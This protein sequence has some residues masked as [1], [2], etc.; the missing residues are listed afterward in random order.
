M[1]ICD[2]G[3]RDNRRI[4][5]TINDT[6]LG[7]KGRCEICVFWP[8]GA[9]SIIDIGLRAPCCVCVYFSVTLSASV[10]MARSMSVFRGVCVCVCAHVN[11]YHKLHLSS[12][13]DF[14][15]SLHL[16]IPFFFFF[17]PYTI[18][19]IFQTRWVMEGEFHF[20]AGLLSDM[21]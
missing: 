19:F 16:Y 11:A 7:V 17:C 21:E 9:R 1:S 15:F 5:A 13:L 20:I 12:C 2:S 14:Q 6:T 18:S 4:G 3:S 8:V 10:H